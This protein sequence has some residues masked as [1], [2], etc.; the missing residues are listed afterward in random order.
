MFGINLKYNYPFIAAMIGSSVAI[1]I[2]VGFGLMA[3]SIGV[4]GLPGFLSFNIDRWPLFFIIALVVIVVP[5][6]ITVAYGRKVE[7]NAK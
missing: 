6:V 7:G 2:S 5:F 4:G 1:V 3:N